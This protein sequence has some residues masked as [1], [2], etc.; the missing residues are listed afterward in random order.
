MHKKPYLIP[1]A[2]LSAVVLS[3]ILG[4][5]IADRAAILRDGR[6]VMLI[7]EP[8]DPR[9]MLRGRYVRLNYKISD[10]PS[11]FFTHEQGKA[12][13]PGAPVFV[14][15][16]KAPSGRW[17]AFRVAV[18]PPASW[19]EEDGDVWIRGTARYGLDLSPRTIRVDYGIERFYVPEPDAPQIEKRMRGGMLTDIVVAV[20]NGGRAQI[21]ALRQGTDTI[22]TERLF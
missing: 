1:A 16:R 8:I 3:A 22:Y 4:W 2:L 7:T 20:G 10:L 6:E 12:L 5:M 13:G 15:L 19:Y 9:D 17:F 21:R 14:R 18:E 11:G